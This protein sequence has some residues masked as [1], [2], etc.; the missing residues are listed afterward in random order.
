MSNQFLVKIDFQ[1]LIIHY[2]HLM[3]LSNTVMKRDIKELD[4][5]G[6]LQKETNRIQQRCGRP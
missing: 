1:D 3:G 5:I 4:V 6:I 2:V